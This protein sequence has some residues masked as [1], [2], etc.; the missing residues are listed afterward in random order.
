[1]SGFDHCASVLISEETKIV[2]EKIEAPTIDDLDLHCNLLHNAC[3]I[4]ANLTDH[5]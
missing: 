1:M 5:N 2:N 3:F 4:H